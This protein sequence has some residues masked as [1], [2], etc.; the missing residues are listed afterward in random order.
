MSVSV[1]GELPSPESMDLPQHGESGLLQGLS[2][3]TSGTEE[4]NRLLQREEGIA[5]PELEG[6]HRERLLCRLDTETLHRGQWDGLPAARTTVR[7]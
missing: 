3:S 7:V 5:D 4:A 2:G 6:A 1:V